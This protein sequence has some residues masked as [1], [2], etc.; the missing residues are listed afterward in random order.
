MMSKISGKRLCWTYTSLGGS[1]TVNFFGQEIIVLLTQTW[2]GGSKTVKYVP[3][4]VV[5]IYAYYGMMLSS[6]VVVVYIYY[7]MMLSLVVTVYT[8]TVTDVVVGGDDG[9]YI[10]RDDVVVVGG[11]GMYIL[12]DDVVIGGDGGG[13]GVTYCFARSCGTRALLL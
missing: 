12:R 9:M 3:S 5:M 8:T 13:A 11:D 6:L 1:R 4:L 2:V 10:L 7:G